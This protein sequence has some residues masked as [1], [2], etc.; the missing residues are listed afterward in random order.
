[1]FKSLVRSVLDY[2]SITASAI[3]DTV[4]K[5]FEVIQNNA[6]RIIFKK[7][8]MDKVSVEELREKA[9]ITTIKD[10]HV[11]L[12]NEYYERALI[13]QNPL[14]DSLFVRYKKFKSREFISEELAIET[15]IVNLDQLSLIRS[16]NKLS[17]IK[18]EIYPTTLCNASPI[19][20]ELILDNYVVGGNSG[21]T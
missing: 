6:L 20:R 5:N 16:H 17:L 8:L 2:A 10:R 7:T 13:S 19:F 21:I 9:G 1:M 3:N 11:K 15:D 12:M 14:I 4:K 18:K